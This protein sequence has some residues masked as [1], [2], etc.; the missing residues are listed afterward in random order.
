MR[1]TRARAIRREAQD[2]FGDPKKMDAER[3]AKYRRYYR[4]EK[5]LWTR[6]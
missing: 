1:G 4:R 6:Q 5:R 2:I 3:Y